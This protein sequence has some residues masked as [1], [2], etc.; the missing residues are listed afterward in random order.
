MPELTYESAYA[1]LQQL[2]RELQDD[3]VG[4]D[5]LAARIER[6]NELLKFCRERLRQTEDQIGNLS[7]LAS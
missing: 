5:A 4:I 7:D 3:K 6:A 2:V 1:E